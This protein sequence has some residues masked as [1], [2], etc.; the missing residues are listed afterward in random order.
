MSAGGSIVSSNRMLRLARLKSISSRRELARLLEF[1]PSA[2]AY[3]LFKKPAASNYK[4]FEIPKRKG[5]TR[6]IKAPTDALKL[7]QQRLS[8]LLQDCADEINAAKKR[9][10]RI[11]HGFKRKRSIL[12]NA[13]QHRNRRY[14]FN[15]DLEDFFPSIH[16]GRIRGYF[17]R[18]ASFALH[19]DVATAIAQI[20]CDA[21]ALP[22][23]SPCSPV[24]SN[25][26][27]HVLDMRLV[28]LVSKV[29]CT[30]SR[31][32]DDLTFSTNKK[33]FPSEVA[34]L[35]ETQ[36]HVWIPGVALQRVIE[37]SGFQINAAKTHMQY[38][39]SRQ[40]VTGL[41]VNKRINVRDEYRHTVRA[42]VHSLFTNGSFEV[43][44]A[45]QKNGVPTLEKRAGTTRQLHGMLGFIDSV[46]L[47][48]KKTC[49]SQKVEQI[50]Q[51]RS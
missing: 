6:T 21:G 15:I 27:A 34:E 30:Y 50:F 9:K 40:E 24:I 17:I 37:G 42:M 45:S 12:T 47:Y 3:L 13:Q 44:A 43:Y 48:N 10:D 26:V 20:A 28:R 14:V 25:L 35:S 8:D 5:G 51:A 2:L 16:I 32:A 39:T 29:G 19:P 7:L 4:V 36:P 33:I 31:Y 11:A 22:Q 1:K 38:R 41:I 18:D 23:G 49:L 46:D